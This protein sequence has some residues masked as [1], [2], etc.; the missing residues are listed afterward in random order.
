MVAA[1][2]LSIIPDFHQAEDVLQ[3]VAVVLVREF[4]QFDTSRPFLPWALGIARTW[5]LSR[6]ETW[7]GDPSTSLTRPFSTKYKLRFTTVKIRLLRF[8][9]GSGIA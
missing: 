3:Q 4:G 7:L 9:N 2:V 8:A 5:L 1:F 6:V